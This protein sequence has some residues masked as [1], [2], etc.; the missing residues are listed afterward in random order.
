MTQPVASPELLRGEHGVWRGL[1]FLL[2]LLVPVL[3]GCDVYF[4]WRFP[5]LDCVFDKRSGLVHSVAQDSFSNYAGLMP[6]DV[7]VAVDG[8][9]FAEWKPL[10][11]ANYLAEVRRG[12]QLFTLELPLVP[13]AR[14]NLG[15]CLSAT[16][17]ASV[18]WGA[19]VL[20]LRRRSR[21]PE[22]QLFFLLTQCM[23]LALLFSLAHPQGWLRPFWVML[24]RT[25]SSQAAG[26][27]WVHYALTFP[28]LLDSPRRR[29]W[30]FY[31]YGWMALAI[32]CE[33]SSLLW[34]H[35]LGLFCNVLEPVLA[36]G[37]LIYAH[38][39][40]TSPDARRRLRIILFG[41]LAA[42]IPP[43]LLFFLPALGGLS[44]WMPRWATGPFALVA[45]LSNL[46]AIARRRLFDVD[47]LLGQ[48]LVYAILLS[49]I[50]ALY[51]GLF[52]LI[53]HFRPGDWLAQALLAA[54]LTLLIG[55]SF[56]R[57]RLFV[58]RRVAYFFY[59][60]WYDYPG[61]VG[62]ISNA[63]ARSLDR[64]HLREVLTRQVPEMMQL[65]QGEV[66]FVDPNVSLPLL[67][68]T[69]LCFPLT[70]QNQERAV[71]VAGLRRDGDDFH[72][73]DRRILLTL[74]RQAEIAL[75]NVLLVE[76]LRRQ[77]VIVREAQHRLLRSREEERA[78]LA[79]DLHD[80]PLQLLTGLNL[81]LGLLVSGSDVEFSLSEELSAMR[82]EVRSLLA[83]L[84]QVCAE[85]RPPML[86]A[87]GLGAALRALS[88]EW[89][90]QHRIPVHIEFSDDA[91]LRSLPD[92]VSVNLYRV[93][94]EALT[95]I[96]RHAGAHMV[97]LALHWDGVTLT[98]DLR[99]D[100]RGFV[101]PDTFEGLVEKG[102]FGLAGMQERAHFI[103]GDWMLSSTPGA[104]T[105]LCVTWSRSAH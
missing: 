99:D 4:Q 40:S 26:A 35:Y 34:L 32:A 8:I 36:L 15:N 91:G 29:R 42:V 90:D 7:I 98:L 33:L 24:S 104:G 60:G 28:V 19:G 75:S 43:L 45:L 17:T 70:F 57:S 72:D 16:L 81:Q 65:Q 94:Q 53:H 54:G 10:A 38:A 14:I 39:L 62:V 95:N 103:G 44:G 101:I 83:E 92:E 56:D 30:L 2:A 20:L 59:G 84:R 52:V 77:L 27:L 13:L 37:L 97:F 18:F 31:L 88:N 55:L 78:R 5:V 69:S 58:Q 102:H 89:S 68:S 105:A 11:T 47:Y 96:A 49:G 23:A 73:A 61:V 76:M 85:L 63:L 67:P 80:G 12:D 22:V 87:L 86:D 9:P 25:L 66:H 6:G 51:L 1:L 21:Q 64:E 41:S 79:R 82:S 100:G 3:I 93:V 48:A 50:L 46:Y 74:A 71:W